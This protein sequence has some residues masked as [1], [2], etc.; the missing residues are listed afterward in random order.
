MKKQCAKRNAERC[1]RETQLS[2]IIKITMS[3]YPQQHGGFY[4][5]YYP[6]TYFII[7]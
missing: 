3:H 6:F 1:L 2:N 5:K 7:Y 4:P